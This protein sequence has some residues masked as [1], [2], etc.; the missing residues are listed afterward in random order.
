LH[1]TLVNE[2]PAEY[3][4]VRLLRKEEET[5]RREKKTRNLKTFLL[6]KMKINPSFSNL[7]GPRRSNPALARS[8]DEGQRRVG[9][10][11]YFE[12]S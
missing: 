5:R 1:V 9:E 11:C 6:K 3:P 12:V 7:P 10:L 2:V 8:F 4:Q